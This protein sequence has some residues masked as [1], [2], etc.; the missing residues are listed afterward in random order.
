MLHCTRRAGC[1]A[2]LQVVLLHD[3]TGWY[4][5]SNTA[6]GRRRASHQIEKEVIEALGYITAKGSSPTLRDK[7]SAVPKG[8]G[9][10]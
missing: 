2:V 5:P 6:V 4:N 9:T 3:I 1:T 8:D 7:V 10:W